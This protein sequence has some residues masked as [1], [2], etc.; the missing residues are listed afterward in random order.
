M[1]NRYIQVIYDG[2]CLCDIAKK[3]NTTVQTIAELNNIDNVTS[4]KIGEILM[5]EV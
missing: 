1:S 5:I 4:I 3:Y 2:S